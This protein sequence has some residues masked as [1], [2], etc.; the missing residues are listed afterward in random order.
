MTALAR[1]LARPLAC[2]GCCF[3][4]P[5]AALAVPMLPPW[6]FQ[7]SILGCSH[8]VKAELFPVHND[9]LAPATIRAYTLWI[10]ASRG[11]IVCRVFL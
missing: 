6:L 9:F 5:A 7:C 10:C 8:L 1:L 3:V 11:F 2:N 4:R